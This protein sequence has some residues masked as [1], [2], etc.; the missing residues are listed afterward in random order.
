MSSSAIDILR[1]AAPWVA[2][3]L[4][5]YLLLLVVPPLLCGALAFAWLLVTPQS[6]KAYQSLLVR[7][8]LLGDSFKPGRFSSLE[9]QKS[10]QE[11]ILHIARKPQVI[12]GA[13]EALGPDPD[14]SA[15]RE[16]WLSEQAIEDTRDS[17]SIVAPNGAEFGK[18]DVVVLSVKAKS[19]DRAC[20]FADFVTSE[21]EK[22]L[23]EVRHDQL[24]SMQSELELSVQ[25]LT[26]EYD[27]IAEKVKG[28]E[29]A[30]GSDLPVLRSLLD[31]ASSASD[32]QR[33]L[34]QIRQERRAAEN[35]LEV[36]R[37]QLQLLQLIESDPAQFSVSSSELLTMQP[38][39]KKLR[40]GLTDAELRL[41]TESGRYEPGHPSVV[42]AREV[43]EQTRQQI[44]REALVV[45]EGLR[46]QEST[47]EAKYQ[48]LLKSEQQYDERLARLGEK[49]VEY[50]TLALEMQKRGETLGKAKTDLAQI[51]SLAEAAGRVS[52]ITRIGQPQAD[53]RPDG[54]TKKTSLLLAILGGLII[55]G[56]LV[57]LFYE[58]DP[59]A[60]WLATQPTP[61]VAPAPQASQEEATS[62]PESIS[63]LPVQNRV[64]QLRAERPFAWSRPETESS[65]QIPAAE[66]VNLKANDFIELQPRSNHNVEPS[67]FPL[68]VEIPAVTLSLERAA[69]TEPSTLPAYTSEPE[70]SAPD[71]QP[72]L[73]ASTLITSITLSAET[74]LP[75]H[76]QA[77]ATTDETA[78][79]AL[80]LDALKQTLAE[81]ARAAAANKP[82]G[83][84]TGPSP[85]QNPA[86]PNQSGRAPSLTDRLDVLS[87]SLTNYCDTFRSDFPNSGSPTNS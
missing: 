42:H 39:F 44:R 63:L 82:S 83:E 77:Q 5:K 66:S 58:P 16:T 86:G 69:T 43:I 30:V 19:R 38:I 50:E 57:G 37:K 1:S 68:R 29:L 60:P 21:I 62:L 53:L 74:T 79:S 45:I 46:S 24:V 17:I 8:D 64:E 3:Q 71:A 47:A 84:S 13:L 4:R 28:V 76:T 12:R 72:A 15:N 14:Q 59:R 52:L 33:A 27:L 26:R 56:G 81:A 67:A 78:R 35:E 6:W 80:N 41:L 85:Q 54:L 10:A 65:S 40:E 23:R 73:P 20:R 18:T 22:N 31:R 7:D 61:S 36:A 49:R 9:N 55:G 2:E 51:Q 34:E 32:V 48:R 25:Q 87:Q 70:F 11:T 75:P